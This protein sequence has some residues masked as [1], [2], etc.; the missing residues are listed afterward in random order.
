[1]SGIFQIIKFQADAFLIKDTEGRIAFPDAEGFRVCQGVVQIDRAG[2]KLMA[3]DLH[4][5][6]VE[7]ISTDGKRKGQ[8]KRAG[9]R[10]RPSGNHDMRIS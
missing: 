5:K 9:R 10:Q 3:E 2:G 1:M 6:T 8:Y 4:G 7:G